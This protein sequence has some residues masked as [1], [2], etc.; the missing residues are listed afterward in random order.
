THTY[1]YTH[2]THSDHG[3]SS[4]TGYLPT[5]ITTPTSQLIV[6]HQKLHTEI[7][8]FG[9]H[10]HAPQQTPNPYTDSYPATHPPPT[11]AL[12]I[13]SFSTPAPTKPC[14]LWWSSSGW[15]PSGFA[16]FGFYPPDTVDMDV[17]V[18]RRPKM[19]H[20]RVSSAEPLFAKSGFDSVTN[21]TTAADGERL[22]HIPAWR[23][24]R[25]PIIQ[26]PRV[27]AEKTSDLVWWRC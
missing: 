14:R 7:H 11:R 24:P 12:R 18:L 27:Y 8:T 4:T 1:I 13:K 22:R 5:T 15:T 19:N 9:T 17:G 3:Y 21:L 23:Q 2:I 6:V 26:T 20:R 10:T 16:K 25:T